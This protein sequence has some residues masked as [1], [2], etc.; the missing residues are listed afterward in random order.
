[1]LHRPGANGPEVLL[2]TAA[3][4]PHEW[5]LPKGRIKKRETPVEAARREV[6]EECGVVAHPDDERV[7]CESSF[8]LPPHVVRP[9][10]S[11]EVVVHY[12]AM[13]PIATA[14]STEGRQLAWLPLTEAMSRA[15]HASTT[16]V[17][18]WLDGQLG[19]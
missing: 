16:A 19:G 2:V 9:G 7:W 17:L 4:A 1:M 3:G 14:A 15:T 10:R 6:L 5:V 8:I 18:R 13:T 12:F 11:A